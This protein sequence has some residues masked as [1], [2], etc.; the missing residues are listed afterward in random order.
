[1]IISILYFYLQCLFLP[2]L[3][4]QSGRAPVDSGRLVVFYNPDSDR[5]FAAQ[6]LPLL[7]AYSSDK[8]IPLLEKSPSEGIPAELTTTPVLVWQTDR[9]RSVY[10][11]RYAEFS[12]IENFIR[13]FRS[14][15]QQTGEWK[16]DDPLVWPNGR[17]QTAVKL[18]VTDLTGYP[19]P[20]FDQQAF[21]KAAMNAIQKGL[22][23][24]KQLPSAVFQRTDRRFYLDFHP[25]LD[26]EGKVFLSTEIYSQ[27]DCMQPVASWLKE[28]FTGTMEDYEGLFERTAGQMAQAVAGVMEHSKLGDAFTP[29]PAAAPVVTWDE[30]GLGLPQ[31]DNTQVQAD[32]ITRNIGEK[33]R[34]LG[35]AD[36]EAPTLQFRFG[37]P[38]DRYAG[39][40]S[41]VK[42][43]IIL[44][45][46]HGIRQGT[47]EVETSSLTMGG[48]DLTEKVLKKY[49]KASRF[50]GAR[51][52]FGGLQQLPPIQ[53]AR[54]TLMVIPGEFV[55][56]NRKKK[57][58]INARILPVLSGGNE[59]LLWVQ[60]EFS[61]NITR[62][63]G[64]EGPE[65]PA[66]ARET[67]IFFASFFMEQVNG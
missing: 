2:G 33:W 30:L 18:K 62:D 29:V 65:G 45:K 13:I 63:F 20:A 38:L 35:P 49:I 59:L 66:P 23:D 28:P 8:G 9:G 7:R 54:E 48:R 67:M 14:L 55:L 43:E 34:I 64:I 41:G 22:K 46:D 5:D 47:F 60:A 57:V 39:E 3:P 58:D 36:P 26:Q 50:P 1:M 51:F 24:Y 15:P 6:C 53:T 52:T 12:T 17:A 32:L 21:R 27:F 10:S 19:P 44:G 11:G 31:A 61:L 16:E 37:E 42:G 4:L 40:F 25:Y 56:M